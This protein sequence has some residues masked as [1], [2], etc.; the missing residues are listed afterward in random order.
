[1]VEM[2]ETVEQELLKQ[3]RINFSHVYTC[4]TQTNTMSFPTAPIYCPCSRHPL[5]NYATSGCEAPQERMARF[6]GRTAAQEQYFGPENYDGHYGMAYMLGFPNYRGTVYV[7]TV[8]P[9]DHAVPSNY[10]FGLPPGT[11]M[12]LVGNV[13][14]PYFHVV[15]ANSAASQA[16]AQGTSFVQT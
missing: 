3:R 7:Q 14:S 11:P 13:Y 8:K 1:M 12:A 15:P 6:T 9:H 10:A 2:V 5:G 4:N 16:A